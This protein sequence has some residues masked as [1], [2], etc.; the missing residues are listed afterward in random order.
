M[1]EV[2]KV[3]I[4]GSGEPAEKIKALFAKGSIPAA[5]AGEA[6]A[7][8]KPDL[9]IE[10]LPGTAKEKGV[11]LLKAAS[12]AP[13]AILATTV[14]GGVTEVAAG[15]RREPGFVGLYFIFSPFEDKCLVQIVRG[16]E[17]AAETVEACR[18]AVDKT[19]ATSVVV[20]DA[21]G[22]IVDRVM[23]S[24]INEAA[25]MYDTKVASLEDI[26]RIPKV[27]LNWPLG[28]FEFADLIG[29][30]KVVATLEAASK[31]SIQY[32]PCRLL[33]EM[34]TAGRLGKKAGRG[35]FDYRG[36]GK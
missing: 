5:L 12:A 7:P 2:S 34:V 24:V 10:V 15:S 25:Y 17:T 35:F 14:P 27:C 11:A 29:V 19:G 6:G 22:L 21:A 28:P 3:L 16:L 23:A 31:D 36:S 18:K 33:R 20:A 9:V 30:D 26:N 13:Q 8:A 4:L 1:A 32:M